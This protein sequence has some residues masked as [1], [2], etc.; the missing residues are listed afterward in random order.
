MNLL[1]TSLSLSELSDKA[2][3]PAV[4]DDGYIRLS[5]A[6]LERTP[7]IHLISGL[8][9]SCPRTSSG[10][11]TPTEIAGYTE[12]VSNT[13]KVA[14]SIG[15][16]W[17]MEIVNSQILLR[18]INKPYSNIMLQHGHLIDSGQTKTAM[19]LESLIDTLNWQ[20]EVRNYIDVRYAQKNNPNCKPR[21]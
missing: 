12:W 21:N 19:Q 11:A 3:I 10:D 5:F 4:S 2:N 13:S 15:W 9:E 20:I 14:I 6:K 16:D 18:K 8:D 17:K 1:T 7:L